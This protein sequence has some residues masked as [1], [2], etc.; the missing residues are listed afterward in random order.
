MVPPRAV[1]L[2]TPY[3]QVPGR[4]RSWVESV[5]GDEVVQSRTQVRG[6]SPGCAARLRTRGGMTAFVK[7]VAA[8]R[9]AN[10]TRLFRHEVSVMRALPLVPYR[11]ELIGTYDDGEWVAVLMRDVDGRHANLDR[12]DDARAVWDTVAL[13]SRELT[14]PPPELMI[15]SMADYARLYLRT[16]SSTVSEN[17]TQYLPA[18]A[19]NRARELDNRVV[20]V[21]DRLASQTLCHW[22]VRDDN[23]LLRPDGTVVIVDWGMARV[24]PTWG[25]LVF[26]ALHWV[27]TPRFD[28]LIDDLVP[29]RQTGELITDFLVLLGARLAWLGQQPAPSGL[30]TVTAMHARVAAELLSGARRRLPPSDR[31]SRGG[32]NRTSGDRA[33]RRRR[34]PSGWQET[35]PAHL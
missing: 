28:V 20:T 13:Q 7:A 3:K 21:P 26:L 31:Q 22:D 14:P 32:G 24:G 35:S 4:L 23:L 2:R 33:D 9:N 16:W 34:S 17:P 29:D 12:V 18:W 10:T 19:A 1:G 11:P 30:P 15:S 5:L 8:D 27:A 6:V 25:D